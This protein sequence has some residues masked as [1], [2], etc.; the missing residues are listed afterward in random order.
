MHLRIDQD[1]ENDYLSSL[2][3]CARQYV[4]NYTRRSLLTQTWQLFL[5]HFPNAMHP[6]FDGWYWVFT[7]SFE[8]RKLRYKNTIFLEYGPVQAISSV[9]YTDVT[10][11]PQTLS[12]G[13]GY[14]ISLNGSN[15][16]RL[17][18]PPLQAWPVTQPDLLDA[19]QITF[20]AGYGDEPKDIPQPIINAM[21]LLIG[22]WYQNRE[23][24]VVGANQSQLPSNSTVDAMLA[25]YRGFSFS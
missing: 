20:T 22:T 24:S 4:E 7:R 9:G 14:Q 13:T 21:L 11:T 15:Q 8:Q 2:I 6:V 25:T 3:V 19:V 12:A 17:Y 5:D 16:P 10:G 18:P 23:S 1:V